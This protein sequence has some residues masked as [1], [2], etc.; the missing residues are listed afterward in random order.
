MKDLAIFV[1]L[2]VGMFFSGS[3]LALILLAVFAIGVPVAL[4]ARVGSHIYRTS[5]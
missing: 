2:V 4:V 1:L 5:R 3:A